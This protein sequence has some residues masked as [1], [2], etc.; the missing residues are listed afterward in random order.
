MTHITRCREIAASP[1]AI[2][3]MLADFGSLSAW[4]DSVDHSCVLNSADHARPLGLTRRVQT[5][6]N[7]FVETI[8]EFEPG[9]VLAYQISGV[10]RGFSVSNRWNV[11]TA[12]AGTT[13]VT[14]TS[15][16]SMHSQVLRRIGERLFAR[17]MARRSQE[18]LTSLARALEGT[19]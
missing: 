3:E 5:G 10:P 7:T 12:G 6:R 16:V 14:L 8:V 19:P 4:A 13:T 2:W 17:L 18:L 11:G 9:R 1:A 15:T